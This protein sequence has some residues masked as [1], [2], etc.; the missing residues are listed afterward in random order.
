MAGAFAHICAVN[1]ATGSDILDSLHLPSQAYDSLGNYFEYVELGSVSPDYPYLAISA[2]HATWADL[3][4]IE[5][6][7]K[8]MLDKGVEILKSLPPEQKEKAFA[9]LCGF[10]SHIVG[11][12]VVHPI[13]ELKVGPYHGNEEHHRICEM[14]QDSYIYQRL[15][16]GGMGAAEHLQTGVAQCSDLNDKDKIDPIIKDLWEQMLLAL[17]PEIYEAN[18]PEIDTWHQRFV[19][20]VSLVEERDKLFALARH[21]AVGKG[22]TYPEIQNIDM[23][24][25]KALEIPD[26]TRMDYDD[27]FDKAVQKI[28]QSWKNLGDAVYTNNED[29]LSYFGN[30][31]LDTGRDRYENLVY[32]T[33]KA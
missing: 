1:I 7:T 29:A 2:H 33:Q 28:A 21:V 11:D 26:G 15:N 30:W 6:K 24:Y 5:L 13:V 12:V 31:D 16:L 3:M 8:T 4:H 20:I 14:H 25:I 18:R 9:W 32:W 27:I 17:H 22:L 23:Q 19:S 10:A